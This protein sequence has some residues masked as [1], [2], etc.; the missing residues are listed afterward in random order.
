MKLTVD[1]MMAATIVISIIIREKRPLPQKG[2]YRLARLHSQLLKDFTVASEKRDAMITAYGFHPMVPAPLSAENPMGEG[3]VPSDAF[4]VPDDK[5]E[6]FS[7]AWKEIGGEEIDL[8]V[9]PISLSCLDLGGN[10]P[11]SIAAN[12][13]IAMGDLVIDEEAAH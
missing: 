7:A 1:K 12:E 13:F 11:S 2:S 8:D 6:E 4:A 5:A 9:Q 3:L 10:V